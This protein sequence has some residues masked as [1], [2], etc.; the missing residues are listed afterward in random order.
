MIGVL[1]WMGFGIVVAGWCWARHYH[2]TRGTDGFGGEI[3]DLILV[4]RKL[5][6]RQRWEKTGRYE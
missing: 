5:T 1:C 3:K 4:H 6:K 2:Y